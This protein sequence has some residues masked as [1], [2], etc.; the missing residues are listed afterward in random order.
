VDVSFGNQREVLASTW[1]V[2]PPG[3]CSGA[4]YEH[5]RGPG[6]LP[7]AP[8]RGFHCGLRGGGSGQVQ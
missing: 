5:C 4:R 7:P 2:P 1:Q 6:L 3:E 8:A